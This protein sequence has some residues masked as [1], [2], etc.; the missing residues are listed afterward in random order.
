MKNKKLSLQLIVTILF[1]NIVTVYSQNNGYVYVKIDPSKTSLMPSANISNRSFNNGLNQVFINRNVIKYRKAFPNAKT[2]SLK[3]IYAVYCTGSTDSLKKSLDSLG[4]FDKVKKVPALEILSCSNPSPPVNDTWIA[5]QWANNWAQDNVEANCA[6]GVGNVVPN[7]ANQTVGLVDTELDVNHE[8]LQ[9]GKI[10]SVWGNNTLSGISNSHGTRS[11]GVIAA[12]TNNNLGVSSLG[13]NTKIAFYAVGY[14]DP[15][16]GIWQAYLDG[17]KII[18]VSYRITGENSGLLIQE[19]IDA[20]NEITQNGCLLVVGAGNYTWQT[21][22]QDI[23]NIPGVMIISG[24]A[25]DNKHSTTGH[26]H[27][28]GVDLCAP[29]INVTTTDMFNGQYPNGSY[30]GYWGTSAAA[31]QVAATAALMLAANSCLTNYEI[32]AILKSTTEPIADAA[33]FPGLIGTGRLNAYKAVLKAQNWGNEHLIV[34]GGI[35][36]ITSLDYYKHITVKNNGILNINNATLYMAKDGRITIEPGSRV[37]IVNS[38]VTAKEPTPS[39]EFVRYKWHGIVV[40]GIPT[41]NQ[42]PIANQGY[43]YIKNSRIENSGNAIS[44][45]SLD[46][47]GNIT[48]AKTGGGIVKCDEAT[49]RNNGRHV[50]FYKYLRP[51]GANDASSFV[52][53]TF[54]V[55]G[56]IDVSGGINHPNIMI[57]TWG[58]KGVAFN[59]CTFKNTNGS[60][61]ADKAFYN[62]GVGIHS[63]ESQLNI[64]AV[65]DR[66]GCVD[67][68]RG[69][70]FDLSQG[71]ESFQSPAAT[72]G[73]KISKQ[74]FTQ[75]DRA[76]NLSNGLATSVFKNNINLTVPNNYY[77]RNKSVN[78]INYKTGILGV[79]T[80]SATG[81]RVE[82]NTFTMTGSKVF[83]QVIVPIVMQNTDAIGGGAF[84]RLNTINNTNIGTQTQT[85]NANANIACNEYRSTGVSGHPNNS[86]L[87]LNLLSTTG[88]TPW[89][90]ECATGTNQAA[91]DK[92]KDFANT[93]ITNVRDG[94]HQPMTVKTYLVKPNQPNRPT[95]GIRMNYLTCVLPSGFNVQNFDCREI[96]MFK[97]PCEMT[98]EP[99]PGGDPRLKFEFRKTDLQII[100]GRIQSGADNALL[101]MVQQGAAIPASTVYNS[102]INNSPYLSNSILEAML[103]YS[104]HLSEQQLTNVLIANAALADPI[105]QAVLNSALFSPS[106]ITQITNA[107]TSNDNALATAYSTRDFYYNEMI[108]ARND[109]ILQYNLYSLSDDSL[110]NWNDSII[111]FLTEQQD[112]ESRKLLLATY[113]NI[114]N[115]DAASNILS[116]IV[117]DG[118]QENVDFITY[119]NLMLNVVING[120][121]IYQL[122]VE[123]LNTLTELAT[124]QTTASEA[125]KGVLTLLNGQVFDIFIERINGEQEGGYGKTQITA[126]PLIP[127]NDVLN[128]TLYPNPSL[129]ST[130]LKYELKKFK[131]NVTIEAFDI[132]GKRVYSQQTNALQGNIIIETQNWVNGMYIVKMQADGELIFSTKLSVQ[133]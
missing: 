86:A 84:F 122:S 94:L 68:K 70:F 12:N 111:H 40:E 55:D 57:T 72:L 18:S 50:A 29:S 24:I 45:Y 2:N 49:F 35:K 98:Y 11:A 73:H 77:N 21:N 124:H 126:I 91:I 104:T 76:I 100:S 78:D 1:F 44:T 125:S 64:S 128:C 92:R 85:D 71:F 26:S 43:L 75:N 88:L 110:N 130:T 96:D 61:N 133:H 97:N 33:S 37:N 120:R 53:C 36:N 116:T 17:H 7:S 102:L 105:Y 81:Y 60:I 56:A 115:Y 15:W 66:F 54:E 119:Y 80:N 6:W 32:E 132:T 5:Q 19:W 118:T 59:G 123:E 108:N 107:Q 23:K 16:P 82:Q 8:D 20:I 121:N 99:W 25:Q 39:C 67:V 113:Y 51:N 10:V 58:V 112:I 52:N 4:L 28:D 27:Y 41:L 95:T 48:W 42:I 74:D 31:P 3:N 106:S 131:R 127:H 62:R 101:Q 93:F 14:Y 117:N 69:S 13:Y 114:H 47:V 46:A 83:G 79:Y 34:N 129:N 30:T 9:N 89:F 63:V 87:Q 38:I 103:V 90:G 109:V 22:H 65:T